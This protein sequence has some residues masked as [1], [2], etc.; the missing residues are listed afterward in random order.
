MVG[1]AVLTLA[2]EPEL[3][4]LVC[5]LPPPEPPPQAARTPISMRS[6]MQR[7][8]VCR[9]PVLFISLEPTGYGFRL[10]QRSGENVN[11]N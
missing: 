8:N 5:V 6:P 9:V 1:A 3:V 2:E 11:A 4:L 7:S 10:S